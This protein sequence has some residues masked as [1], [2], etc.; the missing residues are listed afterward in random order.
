VCMKVLSSQ[1][2]SK[3]TEINEPSLDVCFISPF[4]VLHMVS[5]A[6]AQVHDL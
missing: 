4:F 3:Q 2:K 6:C 1:R 5:F